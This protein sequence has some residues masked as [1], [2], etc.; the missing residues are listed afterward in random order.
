MTVQVLFSMFFPQKTRILMPL[1]NKESHQLY[2]SAVKLLEYYS[3]SKELQ[4]VNQFQQDINMSSYSLLFIKKI[5]LL[6]L[7]HL[8]FSECSIKT[9]F[10]KISQYSQKSAC[11][12]VL[13]LIKLLKAAALSTA[14]LFKETPTQVFFYEYCEFFKNTYYGE[15]LRRTL[16]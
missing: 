6:C 14:D 12:G 3:S 5:N 2:I 7:P 8:C 11:I 13:F 9:M 15:H 1:R 10:L 4:N 16:S